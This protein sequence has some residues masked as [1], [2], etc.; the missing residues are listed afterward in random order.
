MVCDAAC[1]EPSARAAASIGSASSPAMSVTS[2]PASRSP[3]ARAGSQIVRWI[4][5]NSS[6]K[7]DSSSKR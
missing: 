7:P 2:C 5:A 6:A 4:A 3:R 1:S